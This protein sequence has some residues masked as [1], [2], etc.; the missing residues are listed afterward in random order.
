MNQ[1]L[2]QLRASV[3]EGARRVLDRIWTTYYQS[4][5]STWPTIQRVQIEFEKPTVLSVLAELPPGAVYA[6]NDCYMMGLLGVLLTTDGPRTER[7]LADYLEFMRTAVREAVRR[8]H[9]QEVIQSRD[10]AAA[11]DLDE[12]Q[13][14]ILS[15]TIQLAG[16]GG[17]R[18]AGGGALWAAG[19]PREIPDILMVQDLS[20]YVRE[21]ASEM[22]LELSAARSR[23]EATA[24]PDLAASPQSNHAEVGPA[25]AATQSQSVQAQPADPKSPYEAVWGRIWNSRWR[26]PVTTFLLVAALAFAI[27]NSLPPSAKEHQLRR[28]AR[29]IEGSDDGVAG[30]GKTQGAEWAAKA[31]VPASVG[32]A[33]SSQSKS[34]SLFVA[35]IR[36][37][38]YRVGHFTDELAV[39][40]VVELDDGVPRWF[41]RLE[42]ARVSAAR[43]LALSINEVTFTVEPDLVPKPPAVDGRQVRFF[44]VSLPVVDEQ[45][46][47]ADELDSAIEAAGL[48]R[49]RT[50]IKQLYVV[51][52]VLTAHAPRY[53]LLDS[54]GTVVL[55]P[56]GA[57]VLGVVY[58]ADTA[59]E[60]DGRVLL[61]GYRLTAVRFKRPS[62]G[63]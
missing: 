34:E 15:S 54:T 46:V 22:A 4:K 7:L 30:M 10:V 24:M 42:R 25:T 29:G 59:K 61:L 52:T 62:A 45:R 1:D 60:F 55:G 51:H 58:G 43:E 56:G 26:W 3:S 6:E 48:V 41:A 9:S 14:S 31:L 17:Q 53:S 8:E 21:R 19:I 2:D 44:R 23:D 11:L 27:W 33:L 37:R 12:E 47:L 38:E 36:R 20:A 57:V 63:D 5:G 39:G 16:L 35:E 13:L 49:G 28:L 18:G 50:R 32:A 40:D